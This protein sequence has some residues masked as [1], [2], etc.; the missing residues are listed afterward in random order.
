YRAV[1][2]AA[3][4]SFWRRGANWALVLSLALNVFV[5]AFLVGSA[6]RSWV[7]DMQEGQNVVIDQIDWTSL[8]ERLPEEVQE[9]ARAALDANRREVRD[10]L[11]ALDRSRVR[12]FRELQSEPLDRA[13]AE[14]AFEQVRREPM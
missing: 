11:R 12:A 5:L 6:T 10:R 1:V 13:A 3:G 2:S 9:E 8:A 7:G 4:P 14:A